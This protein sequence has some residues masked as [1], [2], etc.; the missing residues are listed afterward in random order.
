MFNNYDGI[1]S[2]ISNISVKFKDRDHAVATFAHM[3]TGAYKKTGEKKVLFEGARTW[4]F[5]RQAKAWK[6]SN[7]NVE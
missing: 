2:R 5:Q 7:F 1:N 4:S 6:I 3:L